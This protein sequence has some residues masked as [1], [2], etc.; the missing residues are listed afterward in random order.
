MS[1]L[2]KNWQDYANSTD[3]LN[4][5]LWGIT[6]YAAPAM[7]MYS[8]GTIAYDIPEVAG[9]VLSA[10]LKISGVSFLV[11]SFARA[12]MKRRLSDIAEADKNSTPW[13]PA[14][15]VKSSLWKAMLKDIFERPRFIQE[16]RQQRIARRKQI[17]QFNNAE[18]PRPT[19]D[20]RPSL[21]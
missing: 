2:K 12:S 9:L 7:L 14:P 1:S 21:R 20:H 13:A 10:H 3:L 19:S 16:H 18:A 4:Y 6:K 8:A 17:R 15:L 5:Q 11:N